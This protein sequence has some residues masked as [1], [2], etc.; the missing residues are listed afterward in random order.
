VKPSPPTMTS[1][2]WGER[3]K[4]IVV[5]AAL[6][7][8][9][10]VLW[11]LRGMLPL[12]IVATLL[13]YLLWP[14]VNLIERRFLRVLPFRAR[15]LAVLLAF[16]IVIAGFGLILVLIIPVLAQ[17]FEQVGRNLPQTL[18]DVEQELRMLL[19]RPL[20]IAG[21]PV[22]IE[23]EPLIL[24]DRFEDIS[25]NGS[26]TAAPAESFDPVQLLSGFLENLTSP[27]FSVL[28]GAVSFVVNVAF[29]IV[30]M[31]YF[32][33]DGD[34]FIGRAVNLV[35]SSYRGDVK[36]LLYELS[37]VWNAYLRG[38]LILSTVVGFAVYVAALVLGLPNAPI[39]GLLAGFLEFIPNIG[40]SIALVPAALTALISQSST[41][42][43]LEGLPYALVVIAVWVGIQ[44][45]ESFFLV[46]RVMG[47]SLDLHPVVVILAVIAGASI[48]GALGIILAAPFVATLR[49]FGQYLYGKVLDT[50][51]FPNL[52][53][54]VEREGWMIRGYRL[55]MRF[56][57]V[58]ALRP[59]HW[60]TTTKEQ[61]T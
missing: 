38:Q 40:P 25:G 1:S 6:L 60:T 48:A 43:F 51:P 16:L 42:P 18:E 39:F 36:R 54:P 9:I 19:S 35:P 4:R 12:L 17:Q 27:A 49:V 37:L 50:D 13:S 41:L 28:G 21:R 55:M 11:N 3:T 31:F 45:F 5:V 44:N 33:R 8:F 34:R 29:M 7:F 22:L 47:G 15:A 20:T 32:M 56:Q 61:E 46:P 58:R 23:G 2:R 24:L 30:I 59:N 53:P 52:Y 26:S 57:L 10:F 14:L